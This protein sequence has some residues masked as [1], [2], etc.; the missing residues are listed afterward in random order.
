MFIAEEQN[1]NIFVLLL[2]FAMSNYTLEF[3]FLYFQLPVKQQ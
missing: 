2:C 3:G 1:F